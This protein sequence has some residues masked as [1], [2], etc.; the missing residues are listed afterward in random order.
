V[1]VAPDQEIKINT[2][3]IRKDENVKIIN[4]KD[5][6]VRALNM[7]DMFDA[8]SERLGTSQVEMGKAIM[9]PGVRVPK[10]GMNPHTQDEFAYIIKGSLKSGT[11]D[12]ETTISAGDFS[13]IPKNTPHWSENVFDED[14][15][16]IWILVGEV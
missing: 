9:K 4:E 10:E 2:F 7:Y 15:E 1:N 12:Q 5:A 13:F 14:C 16:L 3:A 11:G 8:L 6:S